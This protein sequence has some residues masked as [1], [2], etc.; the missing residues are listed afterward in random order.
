VNKTP[1]SIRWAIALLLPLALLL[2]W[3]TAA[4]SGWLPPSQTAAPSE[5]FRRLAALAL[6]PQFQS[7]VAASATRLVSGV[8]LGAAFGTASG[9]MVALYRPAR[10]ALAPSLGFFAGLPVVVWMPFWIMAFG[11]GE[12]FR[13]GLVSIATFFL[14][15]ASVFNTSSKTSR[16]FRELLLIYEKGW[17]E[18]I[19]K[20]YVPAS[21]LAIFTAVRISLALAWII[22]FFVEYAIS[23]RG[24]EG[25]GWFI[26]D[27]RATGRV[28]DEFAG[29][30][31]LGILAFVADGI[32]A[33]LQRRS[34]RWA[35]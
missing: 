1:R 30:L 24:S 26:A 7:H 13:T 25:L 10:L 18:R 8:A 21:A 2:L 33:A 19:S 23:Q 22:L 12:A 34:L 32:V 11:I 35:A 29:L 9:I 15:Y 6:D 20:V 16:E 27:A 4:R 5:V 14:V 17:V 28:E 3:E 31:M